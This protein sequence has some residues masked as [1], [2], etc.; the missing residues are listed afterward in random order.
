MG[1]WWSAA[2][3]SRSS[4]SKPKPRAGSIPTG[5]GIGRMS[6]ETA[7]ELRPNAL[8]ILSG[9]R[10]LAGLFKLNLGIDDE[11]VRKDVVRVLYAHRDDCR[12]NLRSEERRV[13]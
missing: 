10:I 6:K 9:V 8:A 4:S 7:G 13:G 5:N 2:M 3:P 12:V 1:R 11:S